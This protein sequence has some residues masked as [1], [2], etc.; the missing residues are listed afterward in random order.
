MDSICV[1]QETQNRGSKL[2]LLHSAHSSQNFSSRKFPVSSWSL[3]EGL[4]VVSTVS[5]AAGWSVKKG[6]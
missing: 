1:H 3:S 5:E 6:P 4:S 2:S